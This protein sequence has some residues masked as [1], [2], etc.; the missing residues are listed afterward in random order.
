MSKWVN[1]EKFEQFKEERAN[2]T[3]EKKS[4]VTYARKYKSPTMGT[5]SKPKEYHMRLIPDMKGNFYKKIYFHMFQSGETWNFIMCPKTEYFECYCPWCQLT[6]LL[7]QGGAADKNRA[8]AYKRKEKFVGNN[9]VVKDPRDADEQD[10]DKW[11]AGKTFLYEFPATIE[12]LIK[13]EI[14]DIENGWGF[15]IFDPED[16]H[17]LIVSIGAKKPDKA[18]KVWP[19]Y[20]LTTFAKKATPMCDD[21]EAAMAT[22]QDIMEY[23][24]NSLK[25]PEEHAAILKSELV[26]DDVKDQFERHMGIKTTTTK[27]SSGAAPK[28]ETPKPEA[29]KSSAKPKETP[30]PEPTPSNDDD[31]DSLLA[32]FDN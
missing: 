3:T 23:V 8:Q 28:Q 7:Y 1:T 26:Y 20:S 18:G 2:D 15:K 22:T 10:K 29:P 12:Q 6:Q 14:T 4:D 27:A 25:T 9:Y 24:K 5:Q 31:I 30:K 19:D 21:I 17:N 32:D 11:L 13:K 16:G